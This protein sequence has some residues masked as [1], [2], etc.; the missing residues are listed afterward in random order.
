MLAYRLYIFGGNDIREGPTDTLWSFDMDL[1]NSMCEQI[2]GSPTARID[3][4]YWEKLTTSG[5]SPGKQ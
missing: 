4:F 5:K 1:V 2:S 3:P